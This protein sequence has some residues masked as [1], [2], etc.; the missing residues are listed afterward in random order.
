MARP[1]STSP[2]LSLAS[3]VRALTAGVS[4][5]RAATTI[6][7]LERQLPSFA[8]VLDLAPAV[9]Q[10]R[11]LERALA[12]HDASTI[13]SAPL[14]AWH[15]RLALWTRLHASHRSLVRMLDGDGYELLALDDEAHR[16]FITLG[17]LRAADA[18]RR[19]LVRAARRLAS[20]DFRSPT[21]AQRALR[22]ALAAEHR[23]DPSLEA[24]NPRELTGTG[25]AMAEPL[26]P[27]RDALRAVLAMADDD[28]AR[29]LD[30]LHALVARL[31]TE[32]APAIVFQHLS[33]W[34]DHGVSWGDAHDDALEEI[35]FTVRRHDGT[36][37]VAE[38]EQRDHL[39]RL[40]AAAMRRGDSEAVIAIT[41]HLLALTPDGS[42]E[43]FEHRLLQLQERGAS[44]EADLL[45]ILGELEKAG[46]LPRKN[47]LLFRGLGILRA[48]AHARGDTE[49]EL[50]AVRRTFLLPAPRFEDHDARAIRA[51]RHAELAALLVRVGAFEEARHHLDRAREATP[52][53][54][55]DRHVELLEQRAALERAAGDAS[56][57]AAARREIERL[58]ETER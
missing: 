58:E 34:L 45:A 38:H 2:I 43:H 16:L 17:L 52:R 39:Y 15:E 18:D 36:S 40:R 8:T 46:G 33:D 21:D 42:T 50:R 57:E 19:A 54:D 32:D 12:A 29:A 20:D 51:E 30:A 13:V 14:D 23:A 4:A 24:T 53:V 7:S 22:E 26:H 5:S 9:A 41:D 48:I 49:A 3:D 31:E 56:A 44:A 27:I 6:A 28:R 47:Q 10:L 1:R 11:T 25:D 55:L 37:R 35:R